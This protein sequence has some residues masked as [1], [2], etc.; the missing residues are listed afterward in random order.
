MTFHLC[1][2]C[3]GVIILQRS[4]PIAG[5]EGAMARNRDGSR[6]VAR[7]GGVAHLAFAAFAAAL[8]LRG[9]TSVVHADA[10]AIDVARSQLTISVS[11][12]GLFSAF[13]DNHVIRAPIAQGALS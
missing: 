12:S 1:I 7:V 10:A 6:R 4:V 2:P 13:A 8:A 9:I 5:K 3:V 11:K